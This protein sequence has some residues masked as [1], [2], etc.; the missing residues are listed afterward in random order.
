MEAGVW[1]SGWIMDCWEIR[2]MLKPTQESRNEAQNVISD[3]VF[4]LLGMLSFSCHCY[5]DWVPVK[6]NTNRLVGEFS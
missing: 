1:G 2:L 6:G 4:L 5:S 3:V